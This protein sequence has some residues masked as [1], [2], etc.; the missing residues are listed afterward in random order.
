MEGA[1]L[2]EAKLAVQRDRCI[3]GQDDAGEGNVYRFAGE[4][5]KQ[6]AIQSSAYTLAT[7]ADVECDADL[8][9][10][11]ETFV[12]P[13]GLAGGIAQHLVAAAGNKEP[14]RAGGGEP[15]EP[16]PPLGHCR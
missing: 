13:V 2:G 6:R 15:L 10:L 16:F 14:V 4:A 9:G 11:P 3:V 1:D 8:N 5:F 7:A 12:V